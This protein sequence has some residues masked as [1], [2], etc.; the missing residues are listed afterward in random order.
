MEV[1]ASLEELVDFKFVAPGRITYAK[2]LAER[3]V[4]MAMGL[5]RTV[6]DAPEEL[7]QPRPSPPPIQNADDVDRDR[8]R[9]RGRPYDSP[10]ADDTC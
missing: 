5:I 7:S 9:D 4:A 2:G 6:K 8:D 1:G 3:V 10:E